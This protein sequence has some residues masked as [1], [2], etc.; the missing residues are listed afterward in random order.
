MCSMASDVHVANVLLQIL[1]L[2]D[3]GCQDFNLSALCIHR[4]LQINFN[5]SMDKL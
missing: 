5:S 3:N 2:Y 1:H 4:G